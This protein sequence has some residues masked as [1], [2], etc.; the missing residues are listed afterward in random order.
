MEKWAEVEDQ[1]LYKDISFKKM[2]KLMGLGGLAGRGGWRLTGFQGGVDSAGSEYEQYVSKIQEA[3]LQANGE[4]NGKTGPESFSPTQAVYDQLARSVGVGSRF[5]FD[6]GRGDAY[7]KAELWKYLEAKGGFSLKDTPGRELDKLWYE[8]TFGEHG[9][10]DIITLPGGE[11][12]TLMELDEV[13]VLMLRGMNFRDL[14]KRSPMDFLNSLVNITPELLTEGLG[15]MPDEYFIFN[16]HALE[17]EITRKYSD[18]TKGE[19]E[20]M[21]MNIKVKQTDMRR[22]W[23]T[24]RVEN[25]KHLLAVRDFYKNIEKWGEKKLRAEGHLK[26]GE[27]FDGKKH[28]DL[29]DKYVWEPL[30]RSMDLAVE[31]VRLHNSAEMKPDDIIVMNE[32]GEGVDN[33]ATKAIRDMFF[34][35]E[36]NNN[37]LVTYFNSLNERCGVEGVSEVGV[38]ELSVADRGFFYHMGRSWY[39]ELGHNFPPDTSDVDWRYILHNMGANSG[40]N[41]V[42]RLWG[43][44]NAY[45]GVMSKLMSLD[46]V[47]AKCASSNSLEKI[48]EIHAGI[49]GLK[50]ICGD[51]P[52]YEMQYYLAQVVA[53][54]FQENSNARLPFLVGTAYS[55]FNGGKISLSRIYG[56]MHA[57]TMTTDGINKYFQELA[58]GNYIAEEGIYGVER[59]QQALGADWQKLVVAE[60]IPNVSTALFLFLIYQ[61]TKKSM[62]EAEGKG[63]K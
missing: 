4:M 21:L 17:Q 9:N 15:G 38:K 62:E 36:E 28:K 51:E 22:M 59:L 63:K 56:G 57:M 11:K 24:D 6:Q 50:G 27:K 49:R 55:A 37:G 23:G 44:L 18:K 7:A 47:L 45:N 54:Y 58:Y 16:E 13:K 41:M 46:D 43:D 33:A 39:N 14:M 40:E 8:Y 60:I 29:V 5:F 48:M 19:K 31:K 42:K 30:Y 20:E 12:M 32:N 25:Q 1:W 2:I 52:A 61:Y 34:G 3:V 26:E 35:T 10:E 53:R